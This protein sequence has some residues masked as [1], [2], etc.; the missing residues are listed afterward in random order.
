M[1]RV[2]V[3]LSTYNGARY[4]PD[5]IASL[6]AQT[7]WPRMSVL[8]RDDGSVDETLPLLHEWAARAPRVTVIS[9]QNLGVLASFGA[10]LAAADPDADY[11]ALADQD[12]VWLPGKVERALDLIGATPAE[13]GLYC[14]ASYLTDADLRR[15]GRTAPVPRGPSF[16]N[17][18]VQNVAPGHTYLATRGLI[19]LAAEGYQP[20]RVIMH[21]AW[22]YLV[23]AAFGTVVVDSEAFTHYRTHGSNAIGYATHPLARNVARF[24]RVVLY[25]REASTRQDL[26]LL[27]TLGE[28][29]PPARREALRRFIHDQSTIRKRCATVR[30][31]PLRLQ[32]PLATITANV[33]YVLGSY[34][35]PP[36]GN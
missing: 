8:V 32:D 18:L 27:E 33:L 13:I 14:S 23:A 22:L 16:D 10:L 15:I 20:E 4:L 31:R 19:R 34:R 24:K 12:D 21:D 11:I 2:Q 7:V 6:E 36:A 30:A 17:A 5:M 9:G 1:S 28:R 3:L 29:L 35:L 26:L 25:G